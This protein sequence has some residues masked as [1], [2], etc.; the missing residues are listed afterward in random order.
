MGRQRKFNSLHHK[1]FIEFLFE[2]FQRDWFLPV[3]FMIIRIRFVISN[4]RWNTRVFSLFN[5]LI[6]RNSF[7]HVIAAIFYTFTLL[8]VQVTSLFSARC[9]GRYIIMHLFFSLKD[10]K[11]DEQFQFKIS[12][13]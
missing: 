13:E 9:I 11:E 10:K 8:A 2:A 4:H 6:A 1:Y 5:N 12:Y 7:T 3:G